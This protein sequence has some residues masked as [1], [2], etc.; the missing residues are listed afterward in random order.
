MNGDVT[1]IASYETLTYLDKSG[2]IPIKMQTG[3]VTDLL[4]VGTGYGLEQEILPPVCVSMEVTEEKVSLF[5]S[6]I[7]KILFTMFFLFVTFS[8]FM[9]ALIW[10]AVSTR[11]LVV[12]P[13]FM[14][15]SCLGS[16][17]LAITAW[18][19]MKKKEKM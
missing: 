13:F 5:A 16:I 12:D 4:V 2:K 6:R 10:V 15:F 8:S 14:L 3:G 1:G 11:Y 9:F 19:A 18:K 17:G 7:G